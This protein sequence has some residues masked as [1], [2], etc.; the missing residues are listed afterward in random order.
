MKE[1][2][3]T[4]KQTKKS[5]IHTEKLFWIMLVIW[6]FCCL[7]T[8]LCSLCPIQWLSISSSKPWHFMKTWSP[9]SYMHI[10]DSSS[11][12]IVPPH[13]CDVFTSVCFADASNTL[14]F[15]EPGWW[16]L[17]AIRVELISSANLLKAC[18]DVDSTWLWSWLD[19]NWRLFKELMKWMGFSFM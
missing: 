9:W 17:N 14:S 12:L 4:S 10:S 1:R 19:K 2:K 7:C 8:C 3:K 6:R 5:P 11:T 13:L 18:L 16:L 15:K